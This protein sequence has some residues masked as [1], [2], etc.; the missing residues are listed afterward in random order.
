[1][2]QG[3]EAEPAGVNADSSL[4]KTA[5][6][7]DALHGF[8]TGDTTNNF[9]SGSSGFSNAPIFIEA[10]AGCG[11]L[12]SVV[13]Q[14]GIQVLP[15]DCPRNCRTP[16]CRLVIM[17]LISK[18]ADTLLRRIVEDYRVTGCISPNLAG[19]AH[20]PVGSR[21]QM[22]LKVHHPCAKV[23]AA[24]VLYAWAD[25]FVQFL[26]SKGIPWTIENPSNSWLWELPEMSFAFAHGIMVHLHACAYGGERKKRTAFLCSN[27]EFLALEK[28]CD[29]TH[30]TKNG[31][32]TTTS[33]SSTL[34][35]RLNILVLFAKNMLT[36]WSVL[37]LVI[38]DPM[39]K[40]FHWKSAPQSTGKGPIYPS[41]RL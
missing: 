29:G 22:D 24:N 10:C 34:Q 3:G 17:D 33:R 25:Q 39:G 15:I 7:K 14:H 36:S 40:I 35:K 4:S 9:E 31:G 1:M 12:S 28:S 5:D 6:S 27:D 16:K 41:D 18:H 2:S 32:T 13:Q 23:E 19:H 26:H 30:P 38:T 21:F 20:A 11:I 8:C 37:H